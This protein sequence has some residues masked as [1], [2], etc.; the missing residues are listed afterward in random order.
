MKA[1]NNKKETVKEIL[2][3]KTKI[4]SKILDLFISKGYENT[5]F[6]NTQIWFMKEKLDSINSSQNKYIPFKKLFSIMKKDDNENIIFYILT[7]SYTNSLDC[8]PNQRDTISVS[9]FIDVLVDEIISIYIENLRISKLLKEYDAY[10]TI[11]SINNYIENT[12]NLRVKINDGKK[13]LL[14]IYISKINGL[15]RGNFKFSLILAKKANKNITLETLLYKLNNVINTEE[16]ENVEEIQS[17]VTLPFL[18]N[19]FEDIYIQYNIENDIYYEFQIKIENLGVEGQ[20][21]F[22]SNFRLMDIFMSNYQN[23]LDTKKAVKELNINLK[24]QKDR[25]YF[26]TLNLLLKAEF[27]ENSLF[28]IYSK[29]KNILENTIK[30]KIKEDNKINSLFLFFP[31]IKNYINQLLFEDSSKVGNCFII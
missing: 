29:I 6:F 3:K 16:Y 20:Y 31:E 8:N 15:D 2:Q 28:Y 14:K 19:K 22:S 7:K 13:T 26:I 18:E 17:N 23:M 12:R 5:D 1:I 27:D 9:I 4:K 21:F 11:S 10:E 25:D 30:F 24:L